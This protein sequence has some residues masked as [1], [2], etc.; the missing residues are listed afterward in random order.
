ML[1]MN[2]KNLVKVLYY[3]TNH[4][5][6]I[7]IME[8]YSKCTNLEFYLKSNFIDFETKTKFAIDISSGLNYCHFMNILH[9]DIK[10]SNVLVTK[11]NVCK[12]CDFGS[13]I[14]LENMADHL[15]YTVTEAI[16]SPCQNSETG[17][18]F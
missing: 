9:L 8:E 3:T 10:A 11:E 12:L 14:K 4:S 6:S 17:P 1:K 5:Y 15:T 2:H 16:A 18:Q 13:S 7:T